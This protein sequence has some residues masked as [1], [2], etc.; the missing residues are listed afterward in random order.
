MASII[1]STCSS[2]WSVHTFIDIKPTQIKVDIL[3]D[4]TDIVPNKHSVSSKAVGVRLSNEELSFCNT[5]GAL[6]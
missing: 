6:L 5:I 2:S 3:E 4:D 1:I